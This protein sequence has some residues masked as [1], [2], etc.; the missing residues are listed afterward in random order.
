[1]TPICAVI[2]DI[3][4]VIEMLHAMMNDETEDVSEDSEIVT[5]D[6]GFMNSSILIQMNV[7]LAC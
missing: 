5:L 3:S 6:S 7:V 1:M 4:D 2:V